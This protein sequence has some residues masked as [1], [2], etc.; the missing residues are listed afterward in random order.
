MSAGLQNHV[1]LGKET[2]YGTPVAPTLFIPLRESD[3]MSI[4]TDVQFI[5]AIKGSAPLNQCA[6]IGKV[7]LNG[8]FD[9]DA[10]PV[11]MGMILKSALGGEVD[12]LV[13]GETVVYKHTFTES[14]TKQSYTIEEK[15]GEIAKRY[16]GFLATMFNIELN[17]GETA[18]FHFEGF[19]KSH[20]VQGSPATPSYETP[21]PFNFGN[22]SSLT[23]GGVE[24]KALIESFSLEYNNN[25]DRFYGLGDVNMQSAYPKGSTLSGSMRMYLD[26]TTDDFLADYIAKTERAI[27]LTITGSDTIGVGSNY[28][29]K[30]TI[31]KAVLKSN[32]MPFGMEY[33]ALEFDFEGLNDATDGLIKVE[34][35]N[36]TASY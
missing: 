9:S 4:N 17:S 28:I 19:A 11:F 5:P 27:V 2:T 1:G 31:P 21:C 24:V 10:Y 35:T 29:L 13:G 32:S 8:A 18:K 14:F 15:Y 7:E 23:I 3:G 26:T 36:L 25:S 30:V 16:A 6:H 34:L 12:A 20:A 33:N 22:V